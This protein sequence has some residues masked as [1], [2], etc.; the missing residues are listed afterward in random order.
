MGDNSDDFPSDPME[1]SDKDNDGFGDNSD[2]F[3]NDPNEYA[4]SDGDGV[5][6]SADDCDYDAS[7]SVD[8]DNDGVCEDGQS[9]SGSSNTDDEGGDAA[10][11]PGFTSSLVIT[12]ILGAAIVAN[13]RREE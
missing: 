5:G 4:D 2:A 13:R 1:W 3:P 11:L 7:G 10:S 8:A 12:S 9:Q 6:N